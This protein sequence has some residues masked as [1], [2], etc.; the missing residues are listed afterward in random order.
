LSLKMQRFQYAIDMEH[1]IIEAMNQYDVK[2]SPSLK[3]TTDLLLN[4]ETK[5]IALLEETSHS[6]PEVSNCI[7]NVNQL[8]EEKSWLEVIQAF[9]ADQA[10]IKNRE[11]ITLWILYAMFDKSSQF[12]RQASANSAYPSEKL[13]FSSLAETKNFIKRQIEKFIRIYNNKIWSEV[14]F[15]PHI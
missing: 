10:L 8:L 6:Y 4:F 1:A 7:F 5:F 12:Y 13:L 3:T 14:G 11:I 15:S 2:N 9:T